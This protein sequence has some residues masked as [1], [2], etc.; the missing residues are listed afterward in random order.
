MEMM[1]EATYKRRRGK[2][3]ERMKWTR[4]VRYMREEGSY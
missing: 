2:F 3:K 4:E 1:G